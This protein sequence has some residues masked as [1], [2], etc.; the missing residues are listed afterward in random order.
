MNIEQLH[1]AIH[2]KTPITVKNFKEADEIRKLANLIGWKTP[3]MQIAIY[4]VKLPGLK[5]NNGPQYLA[6]KFKSYERESYQVFAV[7]KKNKNVNKVD[8]L[9]YMDQIPYEYR[10]YAEVHEYEEIDII[11]LIY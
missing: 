7:G 8:F 2:S 3:R 6:H 1:D 5:G 4:K 10:K 9:F 11:D